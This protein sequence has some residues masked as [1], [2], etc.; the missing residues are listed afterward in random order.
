M[1]ASVE[2]IPIPL[3]SQLVSTI[4]GND[5]EDKNDF[6]V[7]FLLSENADLTQSGVSVSAGSSIVAFEGANSVYMATIRPPQTSGIV[8]VTVRANAVSQGNPQTSKD[9]RVTRFFPD[10]DGEVP[11][12]LFNH[13]LSYAYWRNQGATGRGIACS[14]SRI[15][16]S[17]SGDRSANNLRNSIDFFTYSGTH[18]SAE[19]LTVAGGSSLGIAKIDFINGDLLCEHSRFTASGAVRLNLQTLDWKGTPVGVRVNGITHTRLGV[20]VPSTSSVSTRGYDAGAEAVRHDFSLAFTNQLRS[21]GGA[22]HQNDLIYMYDHSG[23]GDTSPGVSFL[24]LHITGEDEFKVLASLNIA[25]ASR[26]SNWRDI[27]IYGDTLYLLDSRGVYTLD[28]K[29]YRPV[30]THTKSTIY[31]V[32]IEAG[33]TLDLKQ[34]APDAERIVFDVGYDK[35]PHL[36]INTNSELVVGS[37]A[38]TCLVK[39]KAINRIDATETGRF[40]F[41]LI[42]RRAAAPVWR[43]VS[44]LTMRAGSRYDLFQLIEKESGLETPPTIEFR[45]GGTRLAGSRLS[46]GIFTVGTVGGVAE[47]TARKGSHS[48]HITIKIDV[49]QQF[50]VGNPSHNSG[51]IGYHVEIAGIDVTADVLAFP[52]VSETLDPIVI[53]EYRVNEAA[54]TLRNE[55]GKYNSDLAGNFWETNGLNAG[56]FQNSVKIYTKYANGVENLLFTGVINESF[57]P[58]KDATFRLN[59]TDISSRL[60][61][62]FAENF[63]TLEKWDALRKQSDEDSYEGIY[64]PERSLV[65]MQVGTGKARSDRTD[66]EISRLELPSEGPAAENTG[67]MTPNEFRTAGGF[68]P[69]NPLLGFKAGHLSEDVRFLV[70]QLAINKEVYNTEI[71]I[72]GVEVEDPFLLNRGS[73]AFSVEPTRI[74]RLPV[75]WVVGVESGLQT[76]PT[77]LILLSN[78][79]RHIADVLVQYDL[80]GDSYRVLHTFEKGIAVHRIERRSGTNYYILT[81]KKIPQDRSVRQLP[82]QIDATGYAYD[83]VAEDSAIKIYHYN[84]STGNLTEHV[85]EDDSF[86]PQLGIH[87]WVGFENDLYIDEFEGIRPE[88]RGPFKWHNGH[89]Y[90]RY[91]KDSEF[92]VARVDASS[93]TTKMIGQ[94]RHGYWDHLNFAFD[95]NS[96]GTV[97]FAYLNNDA[98]F[99]VVESTST[100]SSN[101]PIANDLSGVNAA[102]QLQVSIRGASVPGV[103]AGPFIRITGTDAGGDPQTVRLSGNRL[104]SNNRFF[105][106]GVVNISERFLT[107]TDVSVGG[108]LSGTFTI[109]TSGTNTALVI[110]RRTSDGTLSTVLTDVSVLRDVTVL[111]AIGGSY[112]GAYECLFHNNHLYL[113]APIQSLDLAESATRPDAKPTFRIEIKDTGMTG[114]RFVTSSTNLNP[115]STRLAP[116]NEIPVRIDFNGTVSGATRNDVT[117]SGGTLSAFSISSDRIDITIRPSETRFHKNITIRL[118]RNAVNQRNEETHIVLDFGVENSRSRNQTKSAGMVL[119]RCN[120]TAASPRLEVLDTWDFATHAACGLTVHDGSV[121]YVEQPRAAT[122]FKPINPDIEGYWTDAAQ[123][124]TMGYNILPERLGALKK[125]NAA[126]EVEALGNVWFTDKPYNVFATRMLSIDGDLHLSAG[127]GNPDELLRYNSL[128]SQAD[129]MVHI[130]YGKTLQY[131]V[132]RFSPTGSIYAALASLAKSVNA[133]LSFEKNVIM[134]SDRRAYRAVTDGATGT[135]T[136]DLSFSDANKPFPSSGYLLIGK[137]ILR[138]SGIS[139]GAFTGVQRGVLGSPIANHADDSEILYL[140]NILQT[141]KLGSP[142]KAITLQSDTNRI[143]NIIRDSGG[144]AEVRD[145]DSIALY[146]ERPYTLELGLTRHEKAWIEEIFK[147]YLEELKD[148]QQIVNI[149]VVPDFSLRLGQIVP[150]AYKGILHAMRIVSVRYERRATHIKGRTV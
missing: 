98:I 12:L 72:P 136:A 60:R 33:G 135:G 24:M 62:A 122:V 64:V 126:G 28:I 150:F 90:Y 108:Y 68:L 70:N 102:L 36:S 140:D 25:R 48:T 18:R 31:P 7:L 30:A 114:E 23:K 107:I 81:S 66:L 111:D 119:Y 105:S 8:R 59:C 11:R 39:L 99:T 91:A 2:I 82:R 110:K 103:N 71:D 58:I 67:Y 46:N 137:E 89:L 34:F 77:I 13:N 41:Y 95:V 20:T 101:V 55:K 26:N 51:A 87:Y 50:G 22:A 53:N 97:Y 143:F 45:S 134:I 138:Y 38:Q 54:I 14:P 40:Q 125:I 121:H 133:T 79:E 35:Q 129:N 75:D 4:S 109:T 47:F 130:V 65:P 123:T 5:K 29:K 141:E 10:A 86:P 17:S 93:T 83:S 6:D 149:Q 100:R 52:S 74:T 49:V 144:I 85:A 56:G 94:P 69:E 96:S 37:G 146:G 116:G 63:G 145:E 106:T 61:K 15:I 42:V 142:Y 16:I 113:L 73:V 118:A 115:T 127:Y 104:Q 132:P 147:S 92:G 57:E 84:T 131:V 19:T 148:L 88:Y 9:I 117:I 120:V 32:F 139:G 27:A 43:N 124:E 21:I 80:K 76:P 112:L 44:E 1:P 128:A 3:G 78:P